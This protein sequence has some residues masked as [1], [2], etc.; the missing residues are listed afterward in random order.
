MGTEYDFQAKFLQYRFSSGKCHKHVLLKL[1][2]T[3]LLAFAFEI[4]PNINYHD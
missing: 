4:P 2:R 1:R 3:L